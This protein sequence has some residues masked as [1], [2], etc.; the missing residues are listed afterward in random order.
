MP[1]H[2]RMFVA[3]IVALSVLATAFLCMAFFTSNRSA[4]LQFP[5]I[6]LTQPK[7]KP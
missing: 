2:T 4:P 1:M 3:L 5:D 6:I 7:L